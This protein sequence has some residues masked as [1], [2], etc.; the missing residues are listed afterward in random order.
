MYNLFNDRLTISRSSLRF[1]DYDYCYSVLE[2][3]L[4]TTLRYYRE[5]PTSVSSNHFL[6]KLIESVSVSSHLA[7]GIYRDRVEDVAD[8]LSMSLNIT[9]PLNIGKVFSPGVFYG[10]GS[11]EILIY[12]A[13]NYSDS[14]LEGD[15]EAFQPCRFLMHPK[16]DLGLDVPKGEQNNIET[17]FSVILI[18]IPLLMCQYRMWRQR[19]RRV[20]PDD[21]KTVMQFVSMYVLPNMLE[22]QLQIALFNRLANQLY[23]LPQ[24]ISGIKKPFHLS[25]VD[26]RLD[27]N[28]G[29]M[30]T[31][32]RKYRFDYDQVLQGIRIAGDTTLR[33]VIQLPSIPTT[34]QVT[35]ALTIARLPVLRFLL[36]LTQEN[37]NRSNQTTNN[38]M[39]RT[40]NN[41]LSNNSLNSA[42]DKDKQRFV[43]DQL[44]N[45]IKPLL[46]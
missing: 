42:M 24:G 10:S 29:M 12:N 43:I 46:G 44:N 3:N 1:P 4:E 38:K 41:L 14:Y 45:E 6:V 26:N 25:S 13:G 5:N 19:E 17:G 32:Y 27:K 21:Q 39:L 33:D 8:S 40:I 23:K 15:W 28:L 16:S 36:A 34:R 2:R 30:I 22:S 35:W 7:V 20:N 18:D 31:G 9:S 37:D 11:D